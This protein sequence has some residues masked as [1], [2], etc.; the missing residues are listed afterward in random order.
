MP[1]SRPKSSALGFAHQT[2]DYLLEEPSERL[3]DDRQVLKVGL[4]L[5][6]CRVTNEL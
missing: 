2:F 4:K 1:E 6:L 3:P 5:E